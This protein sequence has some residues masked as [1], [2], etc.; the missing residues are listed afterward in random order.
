MSAERKRL[1]DV[2]HRR[3]L[4]RHWG[5]YQSERALGTVREDYSPG[6]VARDYF[7]HDLD[8][9]GGSLAG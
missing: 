1:L 2:R 7:P 9:D 3:P 6:G 4:W 8:S 5:P